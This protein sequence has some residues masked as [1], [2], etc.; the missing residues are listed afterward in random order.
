MRGD[1]ALQLRMALR[2]RGTLGIAVTVA[3]LSGVAALYL[4][5][6]ELDANVTLLGHAQAGSI[7]TLP[8]W[9]A[10]PWIW[11]V[12]TVSVVAAA[13]GLAVALDREPPWTRRILFVLALTLTALAGLSAL[14]VP[15]PARFLADNRFEELQAVAGRMPDDVA[16]RLA[17]HPAVGL[18][19][20]FT[21][22]AL[23]LLAALKSREG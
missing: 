2:P 22:A 5:W 7:A 11:L 14:L 12:A 4:P 15:P 8:G 20:T 9:Q 13:L 1:L 10:Q 21:E 23:L 16:L 17:V 19:L 3:G 18:W 6:Y